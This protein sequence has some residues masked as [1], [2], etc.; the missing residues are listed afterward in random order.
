MKKRII[1]VL[2]L[3]ITLIFSGCS[4]GG[5]KGVKLSNNASPEEL[6]DMFIEGFNDR[7]VDKI[8][9]TFPEFTHSYYR[10]NLQKEVDAIDEQFGTDAT[11]YYN[12]EGKSNVD[13]GGRHF[14][15]T[16]SVINGHLKENMDNYVETNE[17]YDLEGGMGIKGSKNSFYD[18]FEGYCYC[19]F[20]GTWRL[21][22]G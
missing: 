13:D 17:C 6:L 16:T 10:E 15:K 5:K 11:M 8:L 1:I 22:I 21:L 18:G 19:N 12:L 7:D 20:N 4:L 3:T 2:L 9:A 14:C